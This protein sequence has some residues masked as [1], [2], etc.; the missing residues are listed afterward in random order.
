MRN[1]LLTVALWDH[2]WV[3]WMDSDLWDV[4]RNLVHQLMASKKD[5]VVPN[6]I[7]AGSDP[8][9][10]YD[11][12]SWQETPESQEAIRDLPK[13]Q[14]VVEGYG[15]RPTFRKHIGS[16]GHQCPV[17]TRLHGGLNDGRYNNSNCVVRLDGIGGSSIL[18][19]GDLFRSGLNFPAFVFEHAVETE[20][21]AKMAIAMGVQPYGMPNVHVVHK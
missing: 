9:R 16:L 20:G 21:L 7:V 8:P 11:L 13:D 2:D 14:L 6:C 5:L 18:A 12:N 1:W 19:R 4:P 17:P 3:L 10:T 15:D